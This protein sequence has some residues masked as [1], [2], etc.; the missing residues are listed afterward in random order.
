MLKYVISYLFFDSL[1]LFFYCCS[2]ECFTT[3]LERQYIIRGLVLHAVSNPSILYSPWSTYRNYFLNANSGVTPKP[4]QIWPPKKQKHLQQ[5]VNM[6]GHDV[7]L[8]ALTKVTIV[9]FH[10]CPSTD[11][12]IIP[13]SNY[14]DYTLQSRTRGLYLLITHIVLFCFSLH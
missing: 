14:M 5:Y 7:Y 12:L 8:S 1:A 2:Y 3:G 9:I 6:F 4:C 10:Q 11:I 13:P